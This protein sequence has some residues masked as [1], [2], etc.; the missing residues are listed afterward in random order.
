[1]STAYYFDEQKFK[2]IIV[3]YLNSNCDFNS[4]PIAIKKPMRV[5]IQDNIPFIWVSDG[6]HFIEVLFTK[7]AINEYRKN[8]NHIK[9]SSLKDKILFVGK[10]S[11]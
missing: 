8:Y 6:Y 7:D 2:P 5:F 4:M 1:M 11:I 10:W 9:F 3:S